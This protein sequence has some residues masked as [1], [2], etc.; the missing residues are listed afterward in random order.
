MQTHFKKLSRCKVSRKRLSEESTDGP[1]PQEE[2]RKAVALLFYCS[3]CMPAVSSSLI[4]DV[5]AYGCIHREVDQTPCRCAGPLC[6]GGVMPV[7]SA[8]VAASHPG[9]A[10]WSPAR[11]PTHTC[12]LQ[13][14]G[15]HT[16]TIHILETHLHSPHSCY[17]PC[18]LCCPP[19][20]VVLP[21]L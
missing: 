5:G 6:P 11:P 20:Q 16:Y 15:S 17:M 3:V 13:H 7:H 14:T 1:A 12:E 9:G 21:L 2:R 4:T 19:L 18:L 10:G 8:R